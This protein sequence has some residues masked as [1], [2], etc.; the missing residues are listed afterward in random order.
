MTGPKQ[1]VVDAV[2]E[3][4]RWS[5]VRCG[6][7]VV[8]ARGVSWSIHHRRPRGSGGTKLAWVNLPANLIT[9]CGDATSPLGCHHFVETHRIFARASGWLVP[10]NGVRLP[11]EVLMMHATHGVVLLD[12]HGSF[13]SQEVPF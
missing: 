5:C 8:G 10:L 12:D 3:R 4:D 9:L 11:S 1:S 7:P 6:T 13:V 2:L